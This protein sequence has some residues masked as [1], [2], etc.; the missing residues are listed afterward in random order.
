MKPEIQRLR[1]NELKYRTLFEESRDAIYLIDKNGILLDVNQAMEDLFGYSREELI[2]MNVRS[3]YVVSSDRDVIQ[4]ELDI[5]GFVKAYEERLLKKDGNALIC[6][7]SSTLWHKEE[8][9]TTVYHGIIRDVTELRRTEAQLRTQSIAMASSVNGIAIADLDG[10]LTYVNPSCLNLWGYED[11][12]EVLGKSVI[13]FLRNGQEST[14]EIR[15]VVEIEGSW[16]GELKAK[17][18]DGRLFDVQASISMV[19]D[20]SGNPLCTIASFLD[21]TEKKASEQALKQSEEKFRLLFEKSADGILLLDEGE[22]LDCNQSAMEMMG[23]LQKSQLLGLHTQD[24]SPQRQPDGRLSAENVDENRATALKQGSVMF[25]WVFQRPDGSQ[26]PA[27]VTLISIPFNGTR[28]L[29]NVFR[30]ISKRKRAEEDLKKT[31]KQL[32]KI[33]DFLPDATW[34]VDAEGRVTVWNRGAEDMTG[35]PAGGILGKG[36]YEYALPFYGT[37]GPVLIDLVRDPGHEPVGNYDFIKREGE[38]LIGEVEASFPGKT[39]RYLWCK[40]SAAYNSK[41]EIVG[42]IESVRD[43]TDQKAMDQQRKQLESQLI[44]AQKMEAMGILASGIAHDFNNILTSLLGF[45]ELSLYDIPE[46]GD[47]RYS[48]SQ[49]LKAGK[50]AKDLVKQILAFSRQIKREKQPVRIN[51]LVKETLKLLRAS[52]P[53]TIEIRQHITPKDDMVLADPSQIHQLIMNLCTNAHHAMRGK[54]GVLGITLHSVNLN[55]KEAA[56]HQDLNPGPYLKLT[57]SDTGHGMDSQTIKSIFEPYFT[58]KPKEVGTG[59]GLS[60]VDGIVRDHGGAILV[61]SE[62]GKGST[63]TVFLPQLEMD[64]EGE[65]EIF[66][67]IPRGTERIL[68]VDDEKAIADLGTRLIGHL[69]YRVTAMTNSIEAI[70]AFLANP[71]H[72]DLVITDMTMPGITGDELA[73]KILKIRPNMPVIICTGFSELISEERAKQMGIRAYVMKPFSMRELGEVI[74]RALDK[75]TDIPQ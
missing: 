4:A 16:V 57:V 43:I 42:A 55:E 23:C 44:Q 50:R 61:Q 62:K 53:R 26:F 56:A 34:A 40:A 14:S 31:K 52:L 72:Y 2:G 67:P 5:K 17:G 33:I 59:L 45:A 7:V 64:Q 39:K 68:L 29:Y 47:A 28:I 3:L 15:E 10:N 48:I 71:H 21:I 35:I 41:G 63:F 6:Q 73:G 36:D 12:R 69:G 46:E 27:E 1:E 49:I 24:L 20:E 19:R 51:L 74:R 70:E 75:N 18:K 8:L 37:R 60:V 65:F 13:L 66:Q 25:E 38:A 30:D 58:T 54:G 22:I 11:E 32:A 9:K